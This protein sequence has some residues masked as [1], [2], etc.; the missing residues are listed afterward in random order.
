MK[1]DDL[2][3]ELQRIRVERGNLDVMS[4]D[5]HY[6]YDGAPTWGKDYDRMD[7]ASVVLSQRPAYGDGPTNVAVVVIEA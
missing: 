3:T 5:P 7:E 2:I 4:W 6:I 1:I